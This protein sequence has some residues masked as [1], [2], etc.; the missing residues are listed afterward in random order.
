MGRPG[1]SGSAIADPRDRNRTIAARTRGRLLY[2]ADVSPRLLLK[3]CT[4]IGVLLCA[5]R[6]LA[7]GVA[8][9][10]RIVA[11]VD[12]AVV[13][14]AEVEARARREV[15][16]AGT[17]AEQ[18]GHDAAMRHTLD[19]MIDRILIKKDAER[20]HLATTEDEVT[21]AMQL[22]AQQAHLTQDQLLEAARQQGIDPAAYHAEIAYQL[23]EAKWLRIP[24]EGDVP[25]LT[26]FSDGRRSGPW[27]SERRAR[28][29]AQ[30]R[31]KA[32]VDVRL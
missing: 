9:V 14:K 15:D 2:D 26:P 3:L 10:D 20:H 8:L 6:S 1:A 13:T 27:I 30:L 12:D 28:C 24:H 11:V 21:R 19:A 16:P 29:V 25:L 31:Q 23:L 7:G 17:H 4:A 22:I 5:S 18:D 32:H